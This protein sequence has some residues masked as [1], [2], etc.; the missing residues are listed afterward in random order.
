MNDYRFYADPFYS[1]DGRVIRV[2][3]LDDKSGL[4]DIVELSAE[5]LSF[6]KVLLTGD[7]YSYPVSF[8][9]QGDEYLL[10]EVADHASLAWL[11]APFDRDT[12][13]PVKGLSHLPLIDSTA[14][15]CEGI[16]YLF[17]GFRGSAAERLYLFYSEG[18]DQDFRPHP[19][20]PVV[21][22]PARARMGG[23]IVQHDGRLF[24]F[25]QN[26]CF[27]YGDGITVCE[28]TELSVTHYAETV[29]GK[30]SVKGSYGPHTIDLGNGTCVADYYDYQFSWLAWY[31][32]L[33]P[34][35]RRRLKQRQSAPVNDA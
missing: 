22:D 31:R 28:I 27:G 33:F 12:I 8:V 15:E 21:I 34:A 32:I 13:I 1:A 9:H 6:Q 3:A 29:V 19:E 20:N 23:K 18:L 30:F 4:G 5:D 17:C 25:G 26:N 2:E 7:H 11:R 10:P 16:V 14:F 35:L 24:R